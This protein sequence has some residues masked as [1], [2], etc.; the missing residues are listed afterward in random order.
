MQKSVI[1]SYPRS[2]SNFLQNVL[3][4]SCNVDALSIYDGKAPSSGAL[5]FKSHAPTKAYL[6][7]EVPRI[8]GVS[9]GFEKWAICWLARDPRDVM[10]SFYEYSCS[11][12]KMRLDQG[13]FCANFDWFLAAPIDRSCTRRV[14]QEP[15]SVMEALKMHHTAWALETR[16]GRAKLFRYEDFLLDAENSFH[17]LFAF[18]GV[19]RTGELLARNELVSQYSN[20]DRERGKPFTWRMHFE[21]YA[22]IISA[23][24]GELSETLDEL[25]YS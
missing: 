20:D 2:G 22:P 25:G 17:E 23:V 16:E 19:E 8:L 6:E 15:V 3:R 12:L 9:S 10:V 11:R 24:E 1:V 5:N 13:R 18:F 4:R 21:K 7:D 14:L